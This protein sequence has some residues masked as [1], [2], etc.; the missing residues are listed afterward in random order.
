VV[1]FFDKGTPTKKIWYYQLNPG[2][3][4][5]KT[6]PLN[7][8]DL[9]EFLQLQKTKTGSAKSWSVDVGD[10]NEDT[11]D[12]TVRNPNADGPAELGRPAEIVAELEALDQESAALVAKLKRALS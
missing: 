8:A 6:N 7:D 9:A 10:L 4:F 5:G 11:W 1:L 12:L 2:R 3:T